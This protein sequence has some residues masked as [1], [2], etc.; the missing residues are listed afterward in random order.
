VDAESRRFFITDSAAEHGHT[1]RCW[2][3][4]KSSPGAIVTDEGST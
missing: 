3:G 4:T 2:Y 1:R